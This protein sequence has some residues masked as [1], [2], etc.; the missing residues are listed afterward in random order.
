MFK[1]SQYIHFN[2][3]EAKMVQRAE[4]YPWSS[5]HLF[6]N[7]HSDLNP[8]M[9]LHA[10]LDHF[11]ESRENDLRASHDPNFVDDL[12]RTQGVDAILDK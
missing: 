2:P 3:V 5:Y 11:A 12:Y 1:V 8:Y 9:N 6:Q 4:D 10:I 7:S